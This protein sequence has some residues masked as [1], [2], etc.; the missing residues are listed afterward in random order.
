MSKELKKKIDSAIKI[1]K[2]GEPYIVD[3]PKLKEALNEIADSIDLIEIKI[4]R[5]RV[6][7]DG[8]IKT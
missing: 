4:D 3:V 1:T 7:V 2:Q 5:L 8:E 6:S